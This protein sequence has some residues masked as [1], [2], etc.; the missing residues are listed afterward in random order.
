MKAEKQN[1]SFKY[2]RWMCKW[3]DTEGMYYLY[4]PS[5][6]EQPVGFRNEEFEC[7]TKEMCKDFINS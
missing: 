7:E 3:M 1:K 4:T 2:K 6:M 5:E